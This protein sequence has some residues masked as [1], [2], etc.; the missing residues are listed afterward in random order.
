MP[1]TSGP[2]GPKRVRFSREA[3]RYMQGSPSVAD[4]LCLE[5]FLRGMQ[6]AAQS[7]ISLKVGRTVWVSTCNHIIVLS[8]AMD[9]V[10]DV[11]PCPISSYTV[12]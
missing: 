2:V 11:K 1:W 12:P 5:S 3:L 9:R 10:I 8:Q 4:R 7:A 6:S